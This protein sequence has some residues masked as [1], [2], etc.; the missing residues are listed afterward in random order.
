[1]KKRQSFIVCSKWSRP[2]IRGF[3]SR[4]SAGLFR[5][6]DMLFTIHSQSEAQITPA[7]LKS[8]HLARPHAGHFLVAVKVA[9]P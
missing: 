7:P 3:D 2:P 4:P 1:M 8:S 5:I 9:F 6:C